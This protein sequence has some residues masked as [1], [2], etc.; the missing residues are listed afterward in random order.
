MKRVAEFL[1]L[2]AVLSIA[3]DEPT[4]Y[5]G[6]LHFYGPNTLVEVLHRD[7]KIATFESNALFQPGVF[8][9][10][11]RYRLE[12]SAPVFGADRLYEEYP[13]SS[14]FDGSLM[15]AGENGT[16]RIH[17]QQAR[18]FY[19]EDGLEPHSNASMRVHQFEADYYLWRLWKSQP[20]GLF[21]GLPKTGVRL[22]PFIQFQYAYQNMQSD[23]YLLIAAGLIEPSYDIRGYQLHSLAS[24]AGLA[25]Q[26]NLFGAFVDPYLS[27]GF[28]LVSGNVD[29]AIRDPDVP[30]SGYV[31]FII[32]YRFGLRVG[33]KH[34]HFRIGIDFIG[35]YNTY[36]LTGQ[37]QGTF[38]LATTP[39]IRVFW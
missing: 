38:M 2:A 17:Y 8:L 3:E 36:H 7:E 31:G 37:S 1:L 25:I 30:R 35:D 29:E 26:T 14:F 20:G 18:R 23:E 5:G 22:L 6:G 10:Y 13:S 19:T 32:P 24:S 34:P 33:Y 12:L 9:Q 4:S 39:Y 21:D 15:V 27:W 16:G 28:G 11:D